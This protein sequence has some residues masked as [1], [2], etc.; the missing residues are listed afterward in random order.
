ML[1]KLGDDLPQSGITTMIEA[2]QCGPLASMG[3]SDRT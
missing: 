1:T 3:M 2:K